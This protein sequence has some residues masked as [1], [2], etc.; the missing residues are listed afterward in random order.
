MPDLP[1]A[2]LAR[3]RPHGAR[4]WIAGAVLVAVVAGAPTAYA[5]TRSSHPSYRT[6]V[7]LWAAVRQTLDSTGTVAPASQ[8]TVAFPVSGTVATVAVWVGQRVTAGQPLATLDDTPLRTTVDQDA[9]SLAAARRTLTTDEASQQVSTPSVPGSSA[10]GAGTGTTTPGSNRGSTRSSSGDPQLDKARATV[11]A[12]QKSLVTAQQTADPDLAAAKADLARE[13]SSCAAYLGTPAGTATADT[14]S[15]TGTSASTPTAP[16]GTSP[17]GSAPPTAASAT[18]PSPPSGTYTTAPTATPSSA[19]TQARRDSLSVTPSADLTTATTGSSCPALLSVVLTDQQHVA[20]DLAAVGRDESALGGA[21]DAVVQLVSAGPTSSGGGAAGL[22]TPAGGTTG[23]Q[24]SRG[25]TGTTASP[26]Q[27]AADQAAIDAAQAVVTQADG[28][29][30]QATLVS[31]IS[32][33]VGSVTL[34]AGAS[35]SASS[36]GPGSASAVTIV[37]SGSSYLVTTS[38]SETALAAVKVGQAATVAVDG[39]SASL[40]GKVVSIG[41]LPT[42]SSSASSGPVSYPVTVALDPTSQR[43]FSGSAADVSIVT[44]QAD[45]AVAVPNSAVRPLGQ[46]RL[47]SVLHGGKATVTTVQVGAVGTTM[48]Q[49]ISGVAAGQRVVLAD[50]SMPLPTSTGAGALRGLVGGGSLGGGGTGRGGTR[51]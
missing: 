32:G 47:V 22:G 6:A 40:P 45:A 16:A 21:V 7:A 15:P 11:T 49:I 35:V 8:A 31:P 38:V 34:T 29:L 27:L 13:T 48:T 24:T 4:A 10:T 3:R 23:G 42:T 19:T 28:A 12:D 9:A 41:L 5:A 33:T 20:T 1:R 14:A 51:G 39:L 18:S 25:S 37:G 46:T 43:L 17:T 30:A 36:G 44:S 2:W 50:L 26:A